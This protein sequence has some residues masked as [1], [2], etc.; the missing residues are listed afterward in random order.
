MAKARSDTRSVRAA[1]RKLLDAFFEKYPDDKLR[2]AALPPPTPLTH[3]V[4]VLSLS[5]VAEKNFPIS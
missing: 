1:V 4:S 2:A 3:H 5:P